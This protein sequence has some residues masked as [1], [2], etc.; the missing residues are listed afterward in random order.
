MIS[1]IVSY[2]PGQRNERLEPTLL[3][4]CQQV[5]VMVGFIEEKSGG[6]WGEVVEMVAQDMAFT[7]RAGDG[8]TEYGLVVI[9]ALDSEQ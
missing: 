7:T 9:S 4:A 5:R 6:E 3:T 1:A 2:F 8:H